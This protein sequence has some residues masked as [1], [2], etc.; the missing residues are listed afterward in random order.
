MAGEAGEALARARA[1]AVLRIRSTA[2]A[3]ALL[4]AAAA[5]VM[6]AGRVSGR[7]G[8]AWDAACW[9]VTGAA[10]VVLAVTAAVAAVIARAKPAVSPTVS[11]SEK[12]AP[13]FYRLVRDLAE[14]LQVP[15]PS[16]IALTPDCDS[17]LEDRRD[18]V[19][20]PGETRATPVLVVGSPFMWWMRVAELRALLAPVV[21]GTGPAVDPGISAARRFVRGLDAAAGVSADGARGG[22]LLRPVFRVL[23]WAVRLLLHGCR[24]HA[25]EMERA[26]AASASER[27]LAVDYGLR[28]VAQEQIGL[29]YAGWDRLLTR[30]ALPAWRM[31]RWPS[32]LDAGVVAALTELS[33]RDR[34]AEGYETRLGERPACDLLEEPGVVD[35]AVSLLAARIFHGGPARPGP[36][37]APVSWARYPEEV[38]DGIWRG[39]A[40]RLV[41][42]LDEARPAA[43]RARGGRVLVGGRAA[44]LEEPGGATL[45]RVID[46]L[47]GGG[48]EELAAR[49]SAAVEAGPGRPASLQVPG[50]EV[51]VC[52]LLPPRTGR[53]LLADH[54][55]AVVCCAAVDT[56]GA[57]PG[58][59]WLD[60]PTLIVGGSR[61]TDLAFPVLRLVENGDPGPLRSW[62]SAVGIRPDKPLRLP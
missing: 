13:D 22:L 28:I 54:V 23:G 8:P 36:G 48:S 44:D 51:T 11:V 50:G 58:L 40:G 38:V 33:R 1:L 20:A 25:A 52:P 57:A 15:A 55:T 59:D 12:S 3:A 35:E 30:V 62:L 2:V 19:P 39:E 16:A 21:A 24:T 49:L 53:E 29:A 14:R 42:L 18:T 6:A 45:G 46:R 5:V 43:A 31:G 41:R 26:V 4:P 9:A 10:L 37:W 7:I 56:A 61:R 47:A 27:A 17:W 32:R 60:G 34:L